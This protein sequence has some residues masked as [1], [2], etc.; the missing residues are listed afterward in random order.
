MSYYYDEVFRDIKNMSIDYLSGN[1]DY[2]YLKAMHKKLEEKETEVLIVGCSHAMNGI[3]ETEMDRETVNLSLSSQDIYYI[4]KNIEKVLMYC[5]PKYCFI[6]IGYWGLYQ[7][8]S[9]QKN[10][11][12]L[13]DYIFNPIF[14][15]SHRK[16]VLETETTRYRNEFFMKLSSS[17]DFETLKN[18]SHDWAINCLKEEGS[19]YNNIKSREK[20]SALYL[21][22]YEWNKMSNEEKEKVAKDRT[23]DHNRFVKYSKTREENEIILG[24][25]IE[26]LDKEGIIPI[27]VI[28]PQTKLYT[29]YIDEKYKKKFWII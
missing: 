19:Y 4:Y 18:L 17:Y 28:F 3:I 22:G 23:A 12:V 26:M 6:N 16:E 20:N 24:N 9:K 10:Q 21:R 2:C 27:V 13:I 1:Y 5:K 29:K 14:Q 11:S 15:D 7:D 25:I 8:L